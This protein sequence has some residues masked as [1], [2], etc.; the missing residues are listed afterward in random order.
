MRAARMATP[1][2]RGSRRAACGTCRSTD[3]VHDAGQEEPRLALHAALSLG[4]DYIGT[5]HLLL[6][7][8][9][10]S[11][12]VAWEILRD[13]NADPKTFRDAVLL[14]LAGSKS[15]RPNPRFPPTTTPLTI[16]APGLR[17][18]SSRQGHP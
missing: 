10:Q 4:H 11:E 14:T 12:S 5:E 15:G 1:F 7:L 16:T 3:A 9:S 17:A 6:G 8:V 2:D 18:R 13:S